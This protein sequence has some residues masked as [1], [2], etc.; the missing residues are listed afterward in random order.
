M[1]K[2]IQ[3][4]TIFLYIPILL[5]SQKSFKQ[6][7]NPIFNDNQKKFGIYLMYYDSLKNRH[8]EI[9]KDFMILKNKTNTTTDTIN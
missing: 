8:S 5:L 2:Y 6:K 1:K 4:W 3:I 7:E 9:S